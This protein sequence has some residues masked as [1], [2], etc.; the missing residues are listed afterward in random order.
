MCDI[1]VSGKGLS[2]TPALRDRAYE[3]LS[4]AV[5]VF[6][7]EPM[8]CDV[9]LRRDKN[10]SNTDCNVAEVT[11]KVPRSV[12]RV[13]ESSF[14]MYV[15]IDEAASKVS[16]QLRKYKTKLLDKHKRQAKQTSRAN[17]ERMS[18]ADFATLV[19]ETVAADDELVREKSV[20]L[21]PMTLDEALVQIDLIGHDFY[22]FDDAS[23]GLVSVVYRRDDGGYGVLRPDVAYAEEEVA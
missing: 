22:M 6:D 14:D 13:S 9:V 21:E 4:D 16:R 17:L 7:I 8:T 2:V 23:T 12:V 19:P 11:V 5:K 1:R 3:K 20:K 15:A 10:R 18:E